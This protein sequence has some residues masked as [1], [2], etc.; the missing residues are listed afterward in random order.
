MGLWSRS[1]R[2]VSILVDQ[3]ST[4]SARPVCRGRAFAHGRRF[5]PNCTSIS[6]PDTTKAS[7]LQWLVDHLGFTSDH[8]WAFGDALN[9]HEMLEW[10]GVGHAMGNADPLTKS[11]RVLK[12]LPSD[13]S[14][15]PFTSQDV[16]GKR[17]KSRI[18]IT[19]LKHT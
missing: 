2:R 7:A 15:L 19:L 16:V 10:A 3:S 11:N 14:A 6:L 18:F 13:R 9:D 1:S 8:V 4:S 17:S 12:N 5:I